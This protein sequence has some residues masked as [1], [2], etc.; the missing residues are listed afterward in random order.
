MKKSKYLKPSE[1]QVLHVQVVATKQISPSFLRGTL[2]G[3]SLRQFQP[4]GFDQWF[5]LVVPN[6]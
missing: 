1:R 6:E 4:M 2:G 3:E 5:R